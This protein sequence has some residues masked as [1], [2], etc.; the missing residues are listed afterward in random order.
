MAK[1]VELLVTLR[2][3]DQ[4]WL[5]GEVFDYDKMPGEVAAEIS[6]GRGTVRVFEEYV[7]PP[8]SVPP[9]ETPVDEPSFSEVAKSLLE[10]EET[11]EE[12][13]EGEK[14]SRYLIN[15][16]GGGWYDVID[17]ETGAL[18]NSKALKK[19]DAEALVTEL[20]EEQTEALSVDESVSELVEENQK[21]TLTL[22][23]E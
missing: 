19:A 14:P 15:H 13:E 6:L 11:E 8:P 16:K 10:E 21:P 18:M 9:P 17:T 2:G 12:E 5:K 22:G 20:E 7:P 3:N 4:L 23:D 1:K